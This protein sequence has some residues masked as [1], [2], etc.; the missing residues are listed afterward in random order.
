MNQTVAESLVQAPGLPYPVAPESAHPGRQVG[1][2]KGE[3]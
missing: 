2:G 1:A 3:S